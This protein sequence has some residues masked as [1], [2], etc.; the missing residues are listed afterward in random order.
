MNDASRE[1]PVINF[2]LFLVV[3]VDLLG[4]ANELQDIRRVPISEDEENATAQ[5]LQRTGWR[6]YTIRQ[7]QQCRKTNESRIST[8]GS[9]ISARSAFPSRSSFLHRCTTRAPRPDPGRGGKHR[10]LAH[11]DACERTPQAT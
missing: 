7:W 5:V 2:G 4:Q 6:A 3:Y 9:L 10:L 1:P 11:F 8:F